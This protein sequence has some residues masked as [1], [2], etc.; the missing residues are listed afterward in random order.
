[1]DR[2][3]VNLLLLFSRIGLPRDGLQPLTSRVWWA[4]P[5]LSRELDRVHLFSPGQLSERFGPELMERMV[6]LL[7]REELF[8]REYRRYRSEGVEPL[9]L[10]DP[11]YPEEMAD[12][13]GHR[14][15]AAP[16]VFMAKGDLSLL[17]LPALGI[18]GSREPDAHM[19]RFAA[20]L[21]RACARQGMALCEGG[22]RGVDRI[23][24]RAALSAGGACVCFHAV[25]LKERLADPSV[26]R[27]ADRGQLLLLSPSLPEEPFQNYVA[28]MRNHL[29][30]AHGHALVAVGPRREE[31][32]TWRCACDNLGAGWT[33]DTRVFRG[34]GQEALCRMGARPIERVEELSWE[35]IKGP[36]PPM[37]RPPEQ[38]SLWDD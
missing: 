22:A 18:T 7:N 30:A 1:M 13:L 10:G 24:E 12:R 29:I 23:A 25:S 8:A 20:G 32:G 28:L 16:L 15:D 19:R 27:A 37:P 36:R 17:T 35:T 3:R 5:R 33:P 21:G 6:A 11:D 9:A 34:E 4:Q 2:R 38:T 14:A 31:G 26:R